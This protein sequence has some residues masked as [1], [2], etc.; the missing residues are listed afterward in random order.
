M[1]MKTLITLLLVLAFQLA[2]VL[3]GA[4]VKPSCDPQR[5]ACECCEGSKA[6]CCMEN[7]QPDPKPLPE[8]LGTGELLKGM[9]M[10]AA[11]T[12]VVAVPRH[13]AGLSTAQAL[14]Q[15]SVSHGGY[16]GVRLAVAFCS[17][18]I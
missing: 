2:Q 12:Q 7:E 17:F 18:V 13:A 1:G 5:A 16:H 11:E 3:P 9:A 4:L 10:K 8:P 6:C 14:A 15:Q